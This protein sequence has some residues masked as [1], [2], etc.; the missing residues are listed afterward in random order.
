MRAR[1]TPTAL[2]FLTAVPDF[3]AAPL[4]N[5]ESIAL[6]RLADVTGDGTA[7][8]AV[9]LRESGALNETLYIYG[10]RTDQVALLSDP[11]AVVTFTNILDWPADDLG[12]NALT[13]TT[14]RIESPFWGCQTELTVFWR[15]NANYFRPTPDNSG[16]LPQNTLA[17][18]LAALEPLFAQPPVDVIDLVESTLIV[19]MGDTQTA[20]RGQMVLAMLYLLDGRT[21]EANALVQ[22]L[23]TESESNAWL[24]RQTGVFLSSALAEGSTAVQVCAALETA[25]SA[26]PTGG[27]CNLDAVLTRLFTEEPLLRDEPIDEQ[28]EA[29]G[30][31]VLET[32]MIT[33]IGRFPRTAVRLDLPGAE[34]WWAFAPQV[35]DDETYAAEAID[36]PGSADD[37]DPTPF[38]PDAIGPSQRV[39]APLFDG[40]TTAALDILLTQARTMPDA[41]LTPEALYVRALSYDLLGDRANARTAY[42][43]LWSAHPDTLWGQLA[44]AH[45]ERR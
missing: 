28:L 15:W 26:S 30:I 18:R 31:D 4:G 8:L 20:Q 35:S 6:E 2:Q 33:E 19:T 12:D 25:A 22:E 5:I 1:A 34:R 13:V 45:L 9:S 24:S 42:F 17:C 36:P 38:T 40:N 32:Q 11:S 37:S 39:Y 21:I 16:F 23:R 44:A 10:L 29:W 41:P 43:D 3:P 27:A 14:R 7:E